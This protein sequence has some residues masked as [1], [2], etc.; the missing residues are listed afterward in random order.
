MIQL[1]LFD[2]FWNAAKPSSDSSRQPQPESKP[3]KKKVSSTFSRGDATL[4]STVDDLLSKAAAP[5]LVGK[6]SVRWNPRLRTT[7]G[8]ADYRKKTIFLNPVLREISQEE[9]DR[10]LRHELAHFLAQHRAKLRRIPPHGKEWRQAC[11]D[12][13][14][15]DEPRCHHIPIEQRRIPPRYFYQC[16]NCNFILQRVRR[17]KGKAACIK[18]CREHSRGRFDP[19]FCFI[20]ITAPKKF[21]LL[22]EA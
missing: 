6:L 12:L 18:C 22:K 19:R 8:L 11:A 15:P 7:V 9:I 16:P 4:V 13:G 21:S 1:W 20:S 2:G 5:S 17:I 10:T 14:I 3:A